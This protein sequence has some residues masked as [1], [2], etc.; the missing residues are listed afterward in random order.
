VRYVVLKSVVSRVFDGILEYPNEIAEL[1]NSLKNKEI[2]CSMQIKSGPIFDFVRI[3]KVDMN[4]TFEWRLIKNGVSLKKTSL[5][6]DVN[7][8]TVET[9]DDMSVKVKPNPSRWSTLDPTD[10]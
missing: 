4:D 10:F 7:C 8:I 9:N 3:L 2:T 5:V 6:S 1:L